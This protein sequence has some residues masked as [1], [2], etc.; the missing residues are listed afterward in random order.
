LIGGFFLFSN[1]DFYRKNIENSVSALY[2]SSGV[3]ILNLL[4]FNANS[5]DYRISSKEFT[6]DIARGCDALAPMVLLI[7]A[8]SVFPFGSISSKLKGIGIGV[9]FLFILN[10]IRLISLFFIGIYAKKYFEFFHVEFWQALFIIISLIFF[11]FW[12]KNYAEKY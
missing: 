5:K 10:L 9:G 6:M 12:I 2:A 1:T 4:G 3:A 7:V 8:I 11:I